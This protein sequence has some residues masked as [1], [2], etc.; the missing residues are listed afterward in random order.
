MSKVVL[1]TGASAGMGKTTACYL[2]KKG[3]KV[4][5]ASR[6]AN[7]GDCIEGVISLKMDVCDEVSVKEAVQL[8]L[9]IEG[10][11]D[12]LVNNAGLGFIGSIEDTGDA[13]AKAI[14]ETNVFGLMNVCRVVLPA[15][16]LAKSGTI[17][18]I[19][20]L[21]GMMGLPYRGIYSATKASVLSI[22]E[23]LS[24]EVKQFNIKVCSVLPGDF[25]TSVNENR[26]T[27]LA[28]SQSVYKTQ[29]NALNDLVNHEVEHADE[30][31]AIAIKIEQI[32]NNPQ[33]KLHYKV[34]KPMQKLSTV[35]HFLLPGRWFEKILM[36]HYKM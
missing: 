30:P 23:A 24:A 14:F 19:S 27:A 11:I 13:E 21:A 12:V 2:A 17:I 26:R 34:A 18:N 22:T 5:G 29:M 25:K 1:I 4:Y 35:L 32:I 15:M 7:P 8:I 9:E 20:S 31:I 28:G 3:H 33:P 36:N 10:R 6:S 16:R